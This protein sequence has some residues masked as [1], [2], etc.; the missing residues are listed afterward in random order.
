M[1]PGQLEIPSRHVVASRSS[2]DTSAPAGACRLRLGARTRHELDRV[3]DQLRRRYAERPSGRGS[4]E[5]KWRWSNQQAQAAERAI[6]E[7]LADVARGQ[8]LDQRLRADCVLA[9]ARAVL[10]AER[11]REI[12]ARRVAPVAKPAAPVCQRPGCSRRVPAGSRSEAI[13]C[14]KSCRQ[15]VSRARVKARP[16]APAPVPVET[17]AWCH[18]P[19]PPGLRPEARHCGKRCR[20][21]SS[22]FALG[23]R[24]S[25]VL[26]NLVDASDTSPDTTAPAEATGR[27]SLARSHSDA[28]PV[29]QAAR[30]GRQRHVAGALRLAYAD[31]PYPG[32]AGLY[33]EGEEVDH[34]ALIDRL[35]SEFPAG[36]A[37]STSASALQNILALCPPGVRVCSW[38][39][40]IRYTRSRRPLS[41]WEALIVLGGRELPSNVTQTATDALSYAGRYRT[42]PGALIGMKPPQFSVWMFAQLGALPGD[43]LV[44]LFPGSGAVTAA[45]ERY[46]LVDARDV[47][48]RSAAR[49][50]AQDLVEPGLT[51]IPLLPLP[52]LGQGAEGPGD[53]SRSA[54]A[55]GARDV[56]RKA[57]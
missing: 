4:W 22:R 51:L 25:K 33:P 27:D 26:P 3:A 13:Y 15:R 40:Q 6:R 47:S 55:P 23:V 44:D 10:D 19:L 17:C 29:D 52:S 48:R 30:R 2:G 12:P 34:R 42:Y 28:S 54:A 35:L 37:L 49:H 43:Q 1:S 20:Q 36:W 8:V 16:P 11:T 45:W 14:S 32:K 5:P 7:L 9:A 18:Q 41:A 39:R 46:T 57:S 24:R 38:H 56:S 21:A 50:V 53:A 31:P